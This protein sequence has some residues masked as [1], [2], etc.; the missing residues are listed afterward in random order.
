MMM[1]GTRET[2]RKKKEDMGKERNHTLQTRTPHDE[3]GSKRFHQLVFLQEQFWMPT[4]VRTNNVPQVQPVRRGGQVH[5]ASSFNR[6]SFA[7]PAR[8]SSVMI[9]KMVPPHVPMSQLLLNL[10]LWLALVAFLPFPSA[11]SLPLVSPDF[12]SDR[13]ELQI[14]CFWP[15][16]ILR[17]NQEISHT[18]M[19]HALKVVGLQFFQAKAMACSLRTLS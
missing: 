9:H 18:F 11:S 19:C 1:K 12:V 14:L 8:R 16:I 13:S 15:A 7:F 10:I 6:H 17:P 3:V 5:A 2:E 4:Y